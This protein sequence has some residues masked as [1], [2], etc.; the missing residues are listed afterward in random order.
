MYCFLLLLIVIISPSE[1]RSNDTCDVVPKNVYIEVGSDTEIVCQSLCVRGKVFWTQNN[2]ILPRNLS[3]WINSSH[4]AVSL[5]NFT[6]RKAALQCHSEDTKEILGGTT[7]RTYSKPTN[8]GCIWHYKKDS[9]GGVPQLFTCRW[10]HQLDAPQQINYTVLCSS[11]LHASYFEICSSHVTTCT[12]KDVHLSNNI[13]LVGNYNVTVRAK[14]HHWEVY[15]DV[16]QFEPHHILQILPPNLN[17]SAFPG[18]VVAEWSISAM[19][20]KHH[21]QVKYSKIGDKEASEVLNTTLE[22]RHKGKITIDKVDSCT[23]YN[24]SVRCALDQAP[25]SEWSLE[26]RLLTELRGSDVKLHLWRKVTEADQ[27]GVR[28]VYAMWTEIPSTC[29]GA[30]MYS[31]HL[32]AN[33]HVIDID[34]GHTVCGNST[35]RIHVDEEAHRLKLKVHHNEALLAQDSV[36][37]PAVGESLPHVANMQTS[38]CHGVI[39]VSWDAP[40]QLVSGYMVDWTS[41]GHRY[42][43]MET[44][45]TSTSLFGLPAKTP[46]NITVT[47]LFDGKTG[48]GTQALH[49]CSS[50]SGPGNFIHIIVEASDKSAH[51]SWSMQPQEVCSDVIFHYVVF[52]GIGEGRQLNITVDGTKQEVHLKDLTPDTQYSTHVKAVAQTGASQSNVKHFNTKKFDPM[53]VRPLIIFGVVIIVGVLF[54]GLCC[55]IQWK[56][57]LKKQVPNPGLS[58]VA[59][60]PS[61]SHQKG[62]FLFRPFSYPSESLCEPVYIEEPQPIST[63]DTHLDPTGVHK[64]QDNNP[65]IIA[66]PDKRPHETEDTFNQSSMESTVLLSEGSSPLSPYR[67]QGSVESPTQSGGKEWNCLLP[68]T[69][70]ELSTP[71]SVYV[72]VDIFEQ[73]QGKLEK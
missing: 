36:Y 45:S 72:T 1:V 14:T 33:K 49:I 7:I 60:W 12:F 48:L 38:S 31:I 68:M 67:S 35:C 9:W 53:M 25:W 30:F 10:K 24:V 58:S 61:A 55:A 15:S 19:S 42:H 70:Q 37:V 39:H 63:P 13:T 66:E 2:K 59:L 47:P 3:R 64:E 22:P 18:H 71:V 46:H 17:L 26:E 50:V 57:F 69:Q 41:D 21:C 52:Y 56:R 54:V 4:T 44:N 6:L 34:Y 11:W 29:Q 20:A 23:Y 28:N 43:W 73:Y 65:A 5:R 27:D 51:V 8:V 40:A 62:M 16:Y 32:T